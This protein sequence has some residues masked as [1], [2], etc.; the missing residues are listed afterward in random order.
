MNNLDILE[1]RVP[2]QVK[3]DYHLTS[4]SL[5]TLEEG[6]SC[7]IVTCHDA[8]EN[9]VLALHVW[10]VDGSVGKVDELL[11]QQDIPRQVSIGL[12][13]KMWT[14]TYLLFL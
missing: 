5:T 8:I 13:M 6:N 4:T 9:V 7:Y 14:S 10:T 3:V 11:V 1:L 2:E 12:Q